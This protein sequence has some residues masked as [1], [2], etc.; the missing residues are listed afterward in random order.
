VKASTKEIPDHSEGTPHRSL[1][2]NSCWS[3]RGIGNKMTN[4]WIPIAH[5]VVVVGSKVLSVAS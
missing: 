3:L 1:K 4:W 2:E 5:S